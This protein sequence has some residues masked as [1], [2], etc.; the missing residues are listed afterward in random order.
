MIKFTKEE[1]NSIIKDYET[2]S[3]TQIST[4]RKFSKDVLRRI[5]RENNIEIKSY[6]EVRSEVK[7]NPFKNLDSPEVQYWLGW[8]AT[9]GGIYRYTIRLGLAEKDADIVENF[10]KFC[11]GHVSIVT[12]KKYSPMHNC[13]FSNKDIAEYLISL[14]ITRKKTLTL[15]LNVSITWAMLL[16][17]IEGDGWT[18]QDK[19]VINKKTIGICSASKT[20]MEQIQDFLKSQGI[21]CN[22]R[23]RVNNNSMNLLYI[24]TIDKKND[25]ELMKQNLYKYDFLVMQRKKETLFK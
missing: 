16:G 17:I 20:F 23:S 14:G 3:L 9:D 6:T 2:M 8:L 18:Y 1:L 11:K 15:K 19:R 7:V 24:I 12:P 21:F 22:I 10:A 4:T 13:S 5:F 25:I